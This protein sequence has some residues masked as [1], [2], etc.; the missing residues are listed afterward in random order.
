MIADAFTRIARL[1]LAAPVTVA[2]S[3][4]D[5]YRMRA[6]LHVR[7]S[8]AGFFREGTHDLCD[9]RVTGQLLPATLETIERLMAAIRSIGADPVR[10]I[11][12]S[13]NLDAQRARGA[14]RNRPSR[15]TRGWSRSWCRSTG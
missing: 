11:E 5:G 7:G 13:E 8:R 3:R 1:E 14:S 10:E 2:G 9:A 4:E 12:L 6:R 15:S